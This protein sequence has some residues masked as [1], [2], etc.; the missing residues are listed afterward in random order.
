MASRGRKKLRRST[1]SFGRSRRT[2][3][4]PNLPR[5]EIDLPKPISQEVAGVIFATFAVLFFLTLSGNLGI[6]GEKTG[7]VLTSLFG[8]GS[9]LLPF[10]C[11]G[12]SLAS[13]FGRKVNFNFTTFLGSFF[14]LFGASGFLQTMVIPRDRMGSPFIDNPLEAA[15]YFGV[16]A[17]LF[18]RIFLGDTGSK[19]LL[20]GF[21]IV[22]GLIAFQ[23]SI[24]GVGRLFL[25]ICSI[26]IPKHSSSKEKIKTAE[27][28][29][30][31][32][33]HYIE[34][35]VEKGMKKI[36]EEEKKKEGELEIRRP[37]FEKKEVSKRVT[38]EKK[39]QQTIPEVD[40]SHWEAPAL[41]LLNPSVSK[42]LIK[43]SELKDMARE[44]QAKLSHYGVN[45]TMHTAHVGPTVTQ[46]TLVPEENLKLSK[47]TNLKSE[48]S[49]ALSAESVRIEAPIPGKN[50][51]GIEIPNKKRTVVHLR[52]IMESPE[53]IESTLSLKLPI[54]R[55]VSGEPI[56]AD[57]SEMPHLL[58]AGSTGSGKSVCV[59]TFLISLLFQH[60]PALLRLILIDPKRIEMMPYNGIPHLLTPVIT[61][62]EKAL[63][64]L[65]WAVVE[66]MRRYQ[67]LSEKKYRNIDECNEK[68]EKKME[69]IVIIIDELADLMMRQ[70]RK[71]T[72][73]LICRIAQMARAV[74]MHLII[75]TQR[76]SVDVIT[77]LI[78]ANIPT[79][80]SFAVTSQ[81]D[82]RTVLDATGAEDL[83]GKGDM[84]YSNP[85]LSKPQRIQGIFVSGSEIERVVNR[86]KLSMVD[87]DEIDLIG[88]ATPGS[89]G[90]IEGGSFD[91]GEDTFEEEAL[92]VI[93]STGKA[94]ASLLQR[95]LSVGYARAARILD[96]LEEK[97]YIG[98]ARGAKP[99][100]IFL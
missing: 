74:G 19:V 10:L 8:I 92:E 86:I 77:G 93:R 26:F 29:T 63:A 98:P 51:V 70:Y 5:V 42:I 72:E 56:I 15:G 21:F 32:K 11:A 48:I 22:G 3:L 41:D 35:E 38:P 12:L 69:K 30:I 76:P 53:Y 28:L 57:L 61:D 95:R 20:F 73:V 97:G 13:F 89:G 67:V 50:L 4:L 37:Q 79:R 49:L 36:M 66:M 40:V 2:S 83:L 18:F 65:R 45:V 60:S 64:A 62:A 33:P 9:W 43:D 87:F 96:I 59:N 99:R 82:S 75:A 25:A 31:L 55:D 84:L 16:S 58:I 39:K 24:K 17:S 78:K 90:G 27:Q 7:N 54:G 46:F 71:D 81:I 6:V 94:S 68:E 52:E 80:I 91:G 100:E 44:I 85:K 88:E 1:I 14:L 23:V 47:I 34:K